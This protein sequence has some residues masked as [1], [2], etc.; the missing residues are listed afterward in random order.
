LIGWLIGWLVGWRV[1]WLVGWLIGWL[2]GYDAR[3]F[4]WIIDAAPPHEP[5]HLH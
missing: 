5:R 3:D 2:V 4:A 1:G